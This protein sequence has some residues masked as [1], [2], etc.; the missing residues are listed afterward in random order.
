M[1]QHSVNFPDEAAECQAGKA[2]V[3]VDLVV[4]VDEVFD[5]VD[6]ELVTVVG[7]TQV[8][9]GWHYP[10][11]LQSCWCLLPISVSSFDLHL[12]YGR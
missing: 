5:H 8:L 11:I 7:E 9:V 3:N 12:L 1:G 6:I 4:N 10:D 2:V